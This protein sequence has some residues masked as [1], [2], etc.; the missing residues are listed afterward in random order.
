MAGEV[1]HTIID[2]AGPLCSCGRRGCAETFISQRSISTEILGSPAK[3]LPVEEIANQLAK[4]NP[5]AVSAVQHAGE[6]LGHL[7]LNLCNTLDPA[8]IVLGGPLSQLGVDFSTSSI[9]SLHRLWARQPID[10]RCGFVTSRKRCADGAA[11]FV[12]HRALY[13][14]VASHSHPRVKPK[15][16]EHFRQHIRLVCLSRLGRYD[17]GVPPTCASASDVPLLL[18]FT[19]LILNSCLTMKMSFGMRFL[20]ARH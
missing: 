6:R 12:L 19:Y 5:G 15:L 2:P 16:V 9:R 8:I 20:Y 11:G 13:P 7:L 18:G 1:G 3:V 4:R 17:M 10:Y 14:F